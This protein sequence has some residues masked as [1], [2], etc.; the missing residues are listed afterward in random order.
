[1]R[2]LGVNGAGDTLWLACADDGELVDL[3][4]YSFKLPAGLERGEGLRAGVEELAAILKRVAPDVVA[5]QEPETSQATYQS[6]VP[7]MSVEIV[8]EF[9]AAEA[10]V[11][12]RRVSR[13]KLRSLLGL[14]RS[15]A[16]SSYSS[17][18]ISKPQ[19]PHWAKKRE[20]AAMSAVACSKDDA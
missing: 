16:V 2:A 8:L 13:A 4:P 18:V 11:E 12:M 5:L 3:D 6:L 1:M 10:G 9:A 15:G 17:E 19:N 20:I 7:R 14:P